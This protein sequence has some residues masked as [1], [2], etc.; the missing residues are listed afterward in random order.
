MNINITVY[1]CSVQCEI[2]N[3]DTDMHHKALASTKSTEVE[4]HFEAKQGMN[5]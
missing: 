3:A 5:E 4:N 1:N 2:Q